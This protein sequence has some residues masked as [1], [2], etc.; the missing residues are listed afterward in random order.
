MSSTESVI[1][2]AGGG[3]AGH[4]NPL[5]ST[6]RA[7]RETDHDFHPLV[8][9]TAE[10][11][12]AELVPAA[13]LELLTVA[14]L[15]FPRRPSLDLVKLP[16]RLRRE[17][18]RLCEEF[19]SR[20]VKALVGFGGYVSTPAYL[21]AKKLGLPI[22]VHEQNARPG[23]ANRLG[24]NYAAGVALTFEDTPLKARRGITRVTGLP[25]RGEIIDLA[26]QLESNPQVVRNAAADFFG[27]SASRPTVLVTGGS[28]GAQVLNESLP[29]ALMQ[30]HETHPELQ[31][32]HLTGKGKNKPV[33]QFVT[34]HDAESWYQ[35][36]DYLDEMHYALT[37]AD[38][39]VCR[40]GAAT[41]A[42]NSALGVP[43][44]YVPLEIGNGE[45]ALNAR[46]VV[47]AGGASILKQRDLCPETVAEILTSMLVP[48]TN[49]QMRAASRKVG[50][51]AGAMSL[52]KLIIEILEA[53]Q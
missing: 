41:V 9:G 21:A 45:Q 22:V 52:A 7:L 25:L 3:T 5:L 49:A 35:V 23:M 16:I 6:I 47:R 24:A 42:E 4:V 11:L 48:E 33:S 14:R 31:V 18:T 53:D 19:T 13:G 50:T 10:G 51:T 44:L 15:P 37:L 1:V 36:R 12:E 46:G 38:V 17:V 32:I 34:V 40:A 30:V 2:F 43:A 39:V 27:F 20:E 28:L 29:S 8:L 26:S